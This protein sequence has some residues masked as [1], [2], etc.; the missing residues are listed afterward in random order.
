MIL[1]GKKVVIM[2]VR[3][4]WSIA[5]GAAQSAYEQGAEV[6]SLCVKIEEKYENTD[7]IRIS[8]SSIVN[9]NKIKSIRP[10][11][12]GKILAT[13]ENNEMNMTNIDEAVETGTEIV[14]KVVGNNDLMKK[15]GV[16]TGC[17]VAGAIVYAG[18]KQLI[19][20]IK[21]KSKNKK[22]EG[23]SETSDETTENVED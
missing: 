7:Y 5:W 22:D 10:D 6:I 3:N 1:K 23:K 16:G 19:G 11:F 9:L 20:F 21:S 17:A 4:K 8:K 18:V 13:M 14:T 15:I 12:G 2:G